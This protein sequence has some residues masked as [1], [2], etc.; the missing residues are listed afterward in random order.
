MSKINS[1]LDKFGEFIVKNMRDKGIDNY[2]KLV[3]RTYN[4]PE[5]KELQ[6]DL[7]QFNESQLSIIKQCVI[8]SIDTAIHDFL[9]ALQESTD[10]EHGIEILVDKTNIA[11]L[12]D[13][14]N[15]ELFSEEGWYAKYSK[16]EE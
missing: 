12:S 4:A 5:L 14:L 13:G 3:N 15:G 8:E 16:Y 7:K 11:K 10:L 2:N 6:D 9:F 1:P